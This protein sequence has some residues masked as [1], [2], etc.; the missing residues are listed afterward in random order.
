MSLTHLRVASFVLAGASLVLVGASASADPLSKEACVDAHSRGQDARDTG[1]VSLARKLFLT[2][3]QSSCPALVQNDCARFANDL[4]EQ[5]PTITFAARDSNGNDLPDTTVYVDDILMVTRLD[6]GRPHDAD[7]GRHVVKF[8]NNGNDLVMTIV[9]N[10]GEKGRAVIAKFPAATPDTAPA[11]KIPAP[12]VTPTPTVL[13]IVPPHPATP[14]T[15]HPLGAKLAIVAG[16]LAV[17]G[18]GVLTFVGKGRVPGDCSTSTHTCTAPP[19]D[20]DLDTAHKAVRLEDI[21]L[22]VGAVGAAALV[23]GFVWYFSG[24]HLE[25]EEQPGV[26]AVPWISPTGGGISLSGRL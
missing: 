17:V 11:S 19:G 6:D 25:R 21:G 23:G 20:P 8:Q 4:T 26:A 14:A 12:T 3:A 13:P 2:C 5:Q 22:T 16:G 7:P 9:L 24:G 10:T 18:G 1:K 15:V